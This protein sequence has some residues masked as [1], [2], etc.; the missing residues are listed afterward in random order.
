MLDTLHP[1]RHATAG[2]HR[3]GL[4]PDLRDARDYLYRPAVTALPVSVRLDE[5]PAMPKVYDQAQLGSCTANGLAGAFEYDLKLQGLPDFMPSRLF[6]YYGERYIEGTVDQDAGAMIRDGV[7][8]LNTLGCPSERSWPYRVAK[9]TVKPP[10]SS[11]KAA[12]TSTV[13]KYER[14]SVSTVAL[15]RAV[16]SGKPV[17]FGVTLYT[18]FEAVGPDGIVPTPKPSESVIGGHC[19]TVVGYATLNG[20]LMFRV[21]NSWGA[22]WG[23]KGYCWIAPTYLGSPKYVSDCWVLTT[24]T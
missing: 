16:A 4:V 12:A 21:R 24:V 15:Q 11:Y 20:R 22:S 23:D 10:A 9:F 5:T 14:V 19:M 1:R 3:L 17:V 18:S 7:K 6:I 8:V 13:A 2:G